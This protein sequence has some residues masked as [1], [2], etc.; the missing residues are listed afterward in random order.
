MLM[1][2]E[3][4]G[5]NNFVLY[6]FSQGGMGSAIAAKIF[7]NGL[8]KKGIK[9]DKMILDSSI[10]NIRKRVKEDAKKRKVPKFIVSVVVR[11][12]NLRVG[13]KLDKLRFSYLLRR[14]PTLIIQTKSDKATTYGMLMEEYNEIAQNKNVQLKV[15]ERGSHTRIYAESDYKEEY[16]QT[17]ANFLKGVAVNGVREE[18]TNKNIQ[19]EVA[20]K[21]EAEE[22]KNDKN[23]EY[24]EK[25]SDFDFDDNE[26][27]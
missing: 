17:V 20:I 6:G 12:F 27:E 8:R 22:N 15:F 24:Y 25:F 19:E 10:A 16:T 21:S 14:I 1:L 13:N 4:F 26:N 18:T 5:K 9:V 3:K 7:N 11:V 2:N 23:S